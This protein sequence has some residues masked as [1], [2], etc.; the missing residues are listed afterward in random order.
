MLPYILNLLYIGEKMTEK[1]VIHLYEF[2]CTACDVIM[3]IQLS[4]EIKGKMECICGS[5]MITSMH[6]EID[7]SMFGQDPEYIE[8]DDQIIL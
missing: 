4:R 1:E 2:T 3:Q 5:D 6:S 7:E 8:S